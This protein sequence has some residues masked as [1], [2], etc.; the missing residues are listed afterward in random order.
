MGARSHG[1]GC[2]SARAEMKSYRGSQA[3][4]LVLAFLS[5]REQELET[6]DDESNVVHNVLSMCASR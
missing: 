1:E 3:E 2:G 5:H 4:I 6:I